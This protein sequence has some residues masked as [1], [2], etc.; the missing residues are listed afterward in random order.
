MKPIIIGPEPLFVRKGKDVVLECKG[1]A[2]KGV[3]F[4][5]MWLKSNELVCVLF[6]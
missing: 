2:Q 6:V 3:T 4:Q 1:F 5:V